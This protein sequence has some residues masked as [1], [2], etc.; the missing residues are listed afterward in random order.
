MKKTVSVA[1]ASTPFLIEE[2]AYTILDKYLKGIR[3]HFAKQSDANE[4]VA[5]IEARIA[6]QFTEAGKQIITETEVTTVISSM[7]NTKDFDAGSTAETKTEPTPTTSTGET[8]KRLYRNPDDKVVA[9]VASGLAAYLGTDVV[10]VRVIMAILVFA[11]GFGFLLYIALWISMPEAKTASQKLE[12]S[13][14]PVTIETITEAVAER[15]KERVEEVRSDKG[16]PSRLVALLVAIIHGVVDFAT[17]RIIPFLSSVIGICIAFFAIALLLGLTV[18][19]SI[20]LTHLGAEYIDFPILSV[21]SAWSIAL[22]TIT[23]YLVIGIP[24]LFLYYFG[25]LLH[26]RRKVVSGHA[27]LALF[28][29]WFIAVVVCSVM[30]F[31][32]ATRVSSFVATSPE[33]RSQTKTIPALDPFIHINAKNGIHVT[34]TQ[35]TTTTVT[36]SGRARDLNRVS[37][38]S[39]DGTLNMTPKSEEDVLFCLFCDSKIPE[40]IVTAPDVTTFTGEN[41]VRFEGALTGSTTPVSITLTNGSWGTFTIHTKTLTSVVGNGSTLTLSGSSTDATLSTENAGQIEGLGFTSLNSTINAS[42][43][44]RIE[45]GSTNTLDASAINGSEVLY[46]GTPI[47]TKDVRNGGKVESSS[48][49]E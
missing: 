34:Y 36:L 10:W 46:G 5:D 21:L 45:I 25:S 49:N 40:V 17:K 20:L 42:N 1:I 38:T 27:S 2:D 13:G 30:A 26:T 41:A 32:L 47:V 11:S 6:E 29:I 9:G 12:M 19:V 18:L 4:I 33:Y 37:I 7:G 14:T 3:T 44:S 15:V 23:G 48:A 43:A 28:S 24:I 8:K 22:V 39:R 31:S 16:L 35:G